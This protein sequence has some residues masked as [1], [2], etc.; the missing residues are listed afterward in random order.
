[1]SA[2]LR[3]AAGIAVPFVLFW[4]NRVYQRRSSSGQAV[5][6]WSIPALWVVAIGL[7]I[8]VVGTGAW[9]EFGKASLH[10][11]A[12]R[13]I[14]KAEALAKEIPKGCPTKETE[15]I[16]QARHWGERVEAWRTDT[17]RF[18]D[19]RVPGLG[20]RFAADQG[21]YPHRCRIEWVRIR[22]DYFASRLIHVLATS[23]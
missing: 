23:R 18:M 19:E 16:A 3:L 22:L 2:T 14:A 9:E 1:M 15:D 4:L 10:S 8:A 13:Q 20:A 12:T 11:T 5:G 6:R 7:A 17:A 21:D